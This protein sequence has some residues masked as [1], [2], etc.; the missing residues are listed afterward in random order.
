MRHVVKAT[1]SHLLQ[2]LHQLLGDCIS[3]LGR[4]VGAADIPRADTGLDGAAHGLFDGA[5]LGWEVE[6]VEEHET[7]GEDRADWV[8]DTLA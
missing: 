7:D 3:D 1:L 6:G 4:A 8:Y 5:G 2:D